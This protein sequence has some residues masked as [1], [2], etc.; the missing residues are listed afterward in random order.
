MQSISFSK[1]RFLQMMIVMYVG[2]WIW[3]AVA[4]YSRYDWVLE[5]L[6]I[7]AALIGLVSMYRFFSF[8]NLSYV[9]IAL[10]LVLHTIGA[11]YSYNENWVDVWM[12]LIFHSQRDNYDRLVHFSFGLLLAYPIREAMSAWTRLSSKWLYVITCV[13]VLAMG[14][15]YEL[16]EMW[17][18]LLVA[19]EIGTLFLGTQGDPWDTHHDMEL[20]LYGAVIAMVVTAIWRKVWAGRKVKKKG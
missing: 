1:N 3:L 5:N 12:K 13:I 14:A 4:P 10:F 8:S 19:P 7:W 6:L 18:A 16:I 15:F 9:W 11:H 17:V 20:A 2:I